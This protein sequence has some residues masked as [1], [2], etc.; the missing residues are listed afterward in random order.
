MLHLSQTLRDEILDAAGAAFPMECCG[1]IEGVCTTDMWRAIAVHRTRNLAD[2]PTH[3]FLVDPQAHFELLRS[4]R[5][6][7]RRIIGCFHSHPNGLSVPSANDRAKAIEPDFVWLIVFGE[8]AG[9]FG[10]N[11]YVFDK[12]AGDFVALRLCL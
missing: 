11:A 2:D 3:Y 6:S 1:L 12:R 8:K 4:L 9:S 5:G 10:L 7:E